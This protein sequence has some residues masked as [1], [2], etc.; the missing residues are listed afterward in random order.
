MAPLRPPDAELDQPGEL[1]LHDGRAARR[2]Q[3]DR[4]ADVEAALLGRVHVERDLGRAASGSRRRP[5][6]RIGLPVSDVGAGGVERQAGRAVA[7]DHLAVLADHEHGLQGV[8]RVGGP[9]LGQLPRA[10]RRR[11]A[12]MVRL[13]WPESKS[14]AP[15]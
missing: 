3:L 10:R 9:D 8:L 15:L 12:G 4:V 13:S 11:C 5:G 14:L 2:R 6:S 7:A 1:G